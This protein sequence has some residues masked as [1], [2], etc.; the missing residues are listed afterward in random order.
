MSAM[1]KAAIIGGLFGLAL[2]GALTYF[3]LGFAQY[4]CEVC[5]TFNGRMQCRTASG[6]NQETAKQAAHDNACAFLVA[7]KTDGFLCGQAPPTQ[8][9][10]QT[11]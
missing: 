7:S 10:C 11:P 2:L 4:T 1:P 8:V 9:T 3:S 6:T 5:V